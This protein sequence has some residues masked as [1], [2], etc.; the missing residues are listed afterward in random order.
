MRECKTVFH[1]QLKLFRQEKGMQVY[2][3]IAILILGYIS[4]VFLHNLQTS[5]TM[6]VITVIMLLKPLLVDSFATEK[7][8]KTL[9]SLL[10]TPIQMEH[11]LHGKSL[12][13]FTFATVFFSVTSLG[14]VILS[15]KHLIVSAIILLSSWLTFY[16][17]CRLGTY[18][19]LNA[20]NTASANRKITLI[21]YPLSL[22]LIVLISILFT[23]IKLAIL[24]SLC[25]YCLLM[26]IILVI[27]ACLIRQRKRYIFYERNTVSKSHCYETDSSH[28]PKSQ[29]SAVFR[30]EVRYFCKLHTLQLNYLVLIFSPAIFLCLLAYANKSVNIS[31]AIILI[32]LMMPRIPTNL[33]SY[34]IGGEKTYKTGESLLSTPIKISSMFLGKS[35]LPILVSI[36]V[37]VS[38]SLLSQVAVGLIQYQLHGF[39]VFASYTSSEWILV[40]P[41][42]M[43]SCTLMTFLTGILSAVLRTPRYGLYV[44]TIIGSLFVVP[45][46]VITSFTR[47]PLFWS[48]LYAIALLICNLGCLLLITKRISRPTL[49]LHL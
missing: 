11:L 2:Y 47:N 36:V 16:T 24:I 40:Y 21:A 19:S 33:V 31:F 27:F 43:L 25:V 12:F 4:P 44:S 26:T 45:V 14:I 22:L 15:D 13:Y 30:H 5:T 49:M 46:F 7:E 29:V 48:I 41:V 18:A 9:E 39:F 6:T 37:L 32:A 10:S 1:H 17:I 34:A 28:S 20:T 3:L 35:L 42:T 8:Q 38:S 23:G